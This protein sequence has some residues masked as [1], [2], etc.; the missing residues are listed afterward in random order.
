MGKQTDLILVDFSKAFDKVSHSK[1]IWKLHKYGIRGNVLGWIRAFLGDRSQKVVVRGEE[2]G[3][4]L[5]TSG[6]PQ[7][8]VLEPIL[9]LI[10]INDLPDDISS[11]VRL[12][13]DDTALYLTIEGA[14]DGVALQKDLDKLAVWEARWDMEFNPSKCQVVQVT[15]SRKT[16]NCTYRLHGYVLETVTSAKY[17]GVGVSSGLTWNSHINRITGNANKTLG[18]LKRNIKTRCQGSGKQTTTPL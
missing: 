16:I 8:S 2:S 9:S 7:G 11:Q 14:D 1:L 15:G 3:S 10:Y 18:F 5:V 13:A 12:F 6:V 17:L 4:V